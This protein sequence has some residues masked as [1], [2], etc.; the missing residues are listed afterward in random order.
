[1][2]ST[3]EQTLR[4]RL[5]AGSE[6]DSARRA[7]RAAT[8]MADRAASE[9]LADVS[10]STVDSPLGTLLA[11]STKRG[12]VRLAFPEE[13][14]DS[15]LERLARAA[16]SAITKGKLR[17][18]ALQL[19]QVAEHDCRASRDLTRVEAELHLHA[20]HPDS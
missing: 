15:V 18:A 8:R 17:D 1:M 19:Q 5:S 12:L 10:Y 13:S 4:R 14:V 3:H 7:A 2:N 11:A 6:E 20:G 9:G 16:Q